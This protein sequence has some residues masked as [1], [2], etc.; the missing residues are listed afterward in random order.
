[1]SDKQLPAVKLAVGMAM[2]GTVGAFA[3]E[4]GLSPVSVVFW[5]CVFGTLFLGLWCIIR[6]YLPDRSLSLK[7]LT[8][9][10]LAGVCM[11]LSWIAFFAGFTLTSIATTTIIY[12]IQPFFV[13]LISAVFL[14]ELISLNQVL[15]MAG[16]FTGVILASG[17]VSP[18]GIINIHWVLGVALTLV[19]A[20]LYAISTLVGKG[21]GQQR[22]EITILC[23]TIVGI[24]L[25]AP[26]TDS[27]RSV[28]PESW[29]WLIGIGV[30]HTGVAY[31]LMYSAYP[32]LTTPV[33]GVL[34]FI[35]PLIAIIVDW[36]F[37][38]H[39]LGVIQMTGMIL[40]ALC[41]LGVKLGWPFPVGLKRKISL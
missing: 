6:G 37:Y 23:Q 41:T 8:Y 25:L 12:H 3:V 32:K 27:F 19:A 40:I 14:R 26:F 28:P 11:V 33:I 15:W 10:S 4:S 1:M 7:R 5:R 22:P 31:V 9:A 20:L 39:Q 35:Y 16:A 17:L 30:L 38:G 2:I 21:L 34:T 36:V 29:G 24:I 18:F 13:V